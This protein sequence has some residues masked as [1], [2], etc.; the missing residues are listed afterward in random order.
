MKLGIVSP[1]LPAKS[2]VARYVTKLL[3]LFQEEVDVTAFDP[4]AE[5][6]YRLG[7][8]EVVG[9][10]SHSATIDK[11]DVVVFHL[12]NDA[13]NHA[14]T[15]EVWK[16]HGGPVVLHDLYMH[17]FF[18]EYW[19]E[20]RQDF[21][22]YCHYLEAE[23]G[24]L[25]GRVALALRDRGLSPLWERQTTALPLTEGI[26]RDATQ[27]IVH[28]RYAAQL[29]ESI[30][31]GKSVVV[32]LP[33]LDAGRAWHP[34]HDERLHIVCPGF[35]THNK[36]PEDAIELA[37]E[38]A[39]LVQR[40]IRLEFLG[41]GLQAGRHHIPGAPVEIRQ[42]GFVDEE[43]F[44]HHIV[45]SN[46]CVC[47]RKPTFGEASGVVVQALSVG[48]PTL[49]LDHGWYAELPDGVVLK[50]DPQ[51]GPTDWAGRIASKMAESSLVGVGERGRH[52][53][54]TEL[55]PRKHVRAVLDAVIGPAGQ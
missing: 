18:A 16:D 2:G 12:G 26:I 41:G 48:I 30:S 36:V 35:V 20:K 50:G 31:P 53:A 29:V 46:L 14:R 47:L 21:S 43:R 11:C 22:S 13:D 28:S 51:A 32:P 6:T 23:Y 42:T 40:R 8:V 4:L 52:Y 45:T 34:A 38:L 55:D 19:I 3:P 54:L 17:H 49:V 37:L 5:G 27:V 9:I 10:R 33:A 25:A 1:I 15:Y 24:S 44:W 7:D 39:R